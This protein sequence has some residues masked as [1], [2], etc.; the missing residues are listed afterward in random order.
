MFG[1]K[2]K[3]SEPSVRY[4]AVRT[5]ADGRLL[6]EIAQNDSHPAVREAAI[7]NPNFPGDQELLADFAQN[8]ENVC[9]RGTAIDKLTSQ[10]VLA[11]IAQNHT[12]WRTR[13]DAARKLTDQA[14]LARIV[15]N[16]ENASVRDAA[17]KRLTDLDL[18]VEIADHHRDW[19]IRETA[20][21]RID[22]LQ[23]EPRRPQRGP[24]EREAFRRAVSL[25]WA[26]M[27]VVA[28]GPAHWD[29]TRLP[30]GRRQIEEAVC[31]V[32]GALRR[33]PAYVFQVA[34]PDVD[35]WLA[36]CYS[37]TAENYLSR[38]LALLPCFLSGPE[39]NA[40]NLAVK[41]SPLIKHW[42][43]IARRSQAESIRLRQAATNARWP[44][45][46]DE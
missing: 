43:Q 14:I 18:L 16:D 21:E 3:H 30:A 28:S 33:E 36:N 11:K 29:Q 32:M 25:A 44:G 13:H 22:E 45:F 27:D 10:A 35:E 4:D 26:Y 17:L 1:P 34:A 39:L 24:V 31:L 6:V 9:V 8:D 42:M 40:R 41:Q 37:V 12:E 2:W 38:A 5:L 46:R 19:Y 23:E 20:A 7:K 15:H